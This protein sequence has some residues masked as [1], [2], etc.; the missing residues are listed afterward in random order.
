MDTDPHTQRARELFSEHEEYEDISLVPR[1]GMFFDDFFF[2]G[3]ESML[4]GE[5]TEEQLAKIGIESNVKMSEEGLATIR[6]AAANEADACTADFRKK[7]MVLEKFCSEL[8]T[9]DSVNLRRLLNKTNGAKLD[10]ALQRYKKLLASLSPGDREAL[11]AVFFDRKSGQMFAGLRRAV[12]ADHIWDTL[13]K[14]FPDKVIADAKREC[15][16]HELTKGQRCNN[17]SRGDTLWSIVPSSGYK[18]P[19]E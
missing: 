15:R 12:N 9:S 13:A 3:Y 7:Q 14:E 8:E 16:N 17:D 1:F 11:D 6:N 10:S 19:N 18:P 4:A 2:A 5:L